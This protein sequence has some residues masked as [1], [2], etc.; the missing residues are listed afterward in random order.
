MIQALKNNY[1]LVVHNK[2]L[3]F[4]FFCNIGFVVAKPEDVCEDT[5]GAGGDKA[6]PT[7]QK[8]QTHL[9]GNG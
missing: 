6:E 2:K 3:I 4:G 8:S 7:S 1:T 9:P 5:K